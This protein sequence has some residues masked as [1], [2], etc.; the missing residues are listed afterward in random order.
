MEGKGRV[1]KKRVG[2]GKGGEGKARTEQGRAG[3]GRGREGQERT[4]I[5]RMILIANL[6]GCMYIC[7]KS[8][9][10]LII[11]VMHSSEFQPCFLRSALVVQFNQSSTGWLHT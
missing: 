5:N 8:L 7:M 4:G 10:L 6:Y 9:L 3:K 11:I 1:G 2:K